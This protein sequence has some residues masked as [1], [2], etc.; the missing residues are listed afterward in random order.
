[1]IKGGIREWGIF[2]MIEIIG[3]EGEFNIDKGGV[4]FY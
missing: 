2:R 1:M 4:Y 3:E